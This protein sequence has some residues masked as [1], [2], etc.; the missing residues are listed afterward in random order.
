M[1]VAKLA[2]EN[3]RNYGSV[4]LE[5][6]PGVN[7]VVG[8]NAQGKTNLLEAVYLLGGLGSPRGPEANLVREGA[9]RSI[10]HA[11]VTRSGRPLKIDMEMQHGRKTRILL[12]GAAVSGAKALREVVVAVFFGPDELALV[13]G[14]PDGRRRFLDEMVVK[15]RPSR[16]GIRR[17]WDRV[18][19]QRNTL[20]KTIPRDRNR[21]TAL[22]TLGVWDEAFCRAGGALAHARLEALA[23]LIPFASK[24]YEAIAGGG[25]LTLDYESKWLPREL[26]QSALL[27]PATVTAA[28]MVD[29]LA[30]RLDEVR[31]RELERGSS[32]AGPQRDDLVLML[33]SPYPPED[34]GP[35]DARS[36]ASQGDQRTTALA[37][38]LAEHDLLTQAWSEEPI[39]L[40]D[41]VFSEL[42]PAR[43]AWLSET[44]RG[45]A[46]TILSSAEPLGPEVVGHGKV[47]EISA[48]RIV[49]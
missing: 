5:L 47:I 16:D 30:A 46:Q 6:D 22:E 38:K 19:R 10:V 33:A 9:E 37:L 44:V 40:L 35:L 49:G 24:R 18:L 32:L 29:S 23:Q 34:R 2:L 25:A 11:E 43:R 7:L 4:T 31:D 21:V 48:G 41:D 14:P 36:F 26:I 15:L 8:R 3:F 42:D 45:P 13:K 12:N 28:E 1:H 39:L 17:E 20:L 27:D